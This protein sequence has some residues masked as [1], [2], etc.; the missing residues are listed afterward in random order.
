MSDEL[1][2]NLIAFD[3][4]ALL[5]A[6]M[7]AGACATLGSFLVVRRQSLIGDA[8]SHAV[9]PG[10]VIAF[11]LTGQRT[12]FTVFIG[13]AI[14]G[15]LASFMINSLKNVAHLDLGG[16]MAVVFPIFFALGI[17][18]MELAAARNVDLD[19]E[20]LLHGQL[21]HIFW[22]P[23]DDLKEIFQLEALKLFPVEVFYSFLIWMLI[24]FVV[25]FFYKEWKLINFDRALAISLGFPVA[26]LE[27]LFLVIL[28]LAI[29]TSFYV[30]GSILVIALLICPAA[31]ARLLTDKLKVHIILSNCIALLSVMSGYLSANLLPNLLGYQHSWNSAGMIAFSSGIFLL[32]AIIFAPDYGI[33]SRQLRRL[34]FAL[35]NIQEDMLAMLFRQESEA[36]VNSDPDYYLKPTSKLLGYFGRIMLIR[37][38]L[39]KFVN[40]DFVLTEHGREK[41]KLLLARHRRWEH[42][43]VEAV[44]LKEDHVHEHAQDLEHIATMEV[45]QAL[46]EETKNVSKDPHGKRIPE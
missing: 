35:Q 18:L 46:Q 32:A 24:I 43:L 4:P 40:S 15:I 2:Y 12:S 38:K 42:Y 22:L 16:A 45:E 21:E 44:G 41:G 36:E 8:I 11:L 20:C 10:I 9:L 26:S 19:A 30:V 6:I 27:L 1:I 13:A 29:V 37:R 14:A 34:R 3:L 31:A 28:T 17:L 23:P 5:T 7:V 39:I 25:I 33:L